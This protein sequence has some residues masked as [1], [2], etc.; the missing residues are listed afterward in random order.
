MTSR[1][2]TGLFL[3]AALLAAPAAAHAQ[4]KGNGTWLGGML[5]PE[6]GSESGLQL[7]GDLEVPITKLAPN[8]S[9]A[10]V[11]SASIA[12]LSH[13][14]N[15]FEAV[16]AGRLTWAGSNQFGAYADLGVGPYAGGGKLGATM[17]MAGGGYYEMSP[18]IRFFGEAGI[19]PHWGDYPNGD[20][21]VWS[22]T[23][24]FGAKFRF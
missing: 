16:V 14:T 6:F 1:S 4:S 2:I 11:G 15:V 7:R 8:L 21:D 19:H 9:L 24:L 22:F 13:K 12:F 17:R 23:L 20:S 3:A 18:T 10:G 5:G